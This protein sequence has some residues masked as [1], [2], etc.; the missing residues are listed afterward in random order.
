MFHET[1]VDINRIEDDHRFV[2]NPAREQRTPGPRTRELGFGFDSESR[3]VGVDATSTDTG[4]A[5]TVL[6]NREP[7]NVPE[8]PRIG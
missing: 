6:G 7:M 1:P 3:R 5:N 4:V 8:P 2:V